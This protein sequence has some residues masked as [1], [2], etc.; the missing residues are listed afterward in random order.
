[1]VDAIAEAA[2]TLPGVNGEAA[3]AARF[4]GQWMERLGSAAFPVEGQ[5]I[6]ELTRTP[7][8]TAAGGR[9]RRAYL[10]DRD[11]VLA[12]TRSFFVDFGEETRDLEPMVERRL[13]AGH[14]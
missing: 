10:Q 5:R 6:Y 12:W 1:L 4:A 13:E 11:L 8:A 7:Q 9:M 3:T 14:F 2:V